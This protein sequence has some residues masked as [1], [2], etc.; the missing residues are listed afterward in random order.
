MYS[1]NSWK[2]PERYLKCNIWYEVYVRHITWSH[3]R[4]IVNKA[5]TTSV[6]AS[7][8]NGLLQGIISSINRILFHIYNAFNRK[9]YYCFRLETWGVKFVHTLVMSCS[10]RTFKTNF[11]IIQLTINEHSTRG[12]KLLVAIPLKNKPQSIASFIF[13][14]W[15][16]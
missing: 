1:W 11:L 9:H 8:A 16:Y 5:I 12:T 3:E 6:E 13:P 10:W 4:Q 15:S 7:I 2:K 14:Q